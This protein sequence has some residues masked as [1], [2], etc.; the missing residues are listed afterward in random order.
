MINNEIVQR[1][2]NN[3]TNE[4]GTDENN[5]LNIAETKDDE[6]VRL[7]FIISPIELVKNVLRPKR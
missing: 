4:H 6:V 5:I 7:L 1:S 2:T 3:D